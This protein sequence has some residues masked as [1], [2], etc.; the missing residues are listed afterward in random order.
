MS[1][2]R[3]ANGEGTVFQLSDG[4]WVAKIYLGQGSHGEWQV[5]QFSGKTEAIVKKKLRDYKCSTDFIERHAPVQD[6]VQAYFAIWLREYQYHKLKP[7]SFDR[8]EST[9]SNHIYPSIGNLK[10][11]KVTR[12]HIQGLI[13]KLCRKGLSYSSIKKVYV[14]LNS[15]FTHAMTADVVLKN[16]C[17]GIALPSPASGTKEVL[18]LGEEEVELLKIELARTGDAG[19][20]VHPYGQAYMLIL[21][22]G[23]RMGEALSLRWTDID[24][25]RKTI[26][27]VKNSILTKKRDE[28]GTCVGGYEVQVQKSTKTASGNRVLPM[29]QS[30]EEALRALKRGNDTE[31]VIVNRRHKPILPSNFERTFRAILKNAGISGN[32]GIHAL[33]HTFASMLFAKGVDVKI[34]SKLLGH[35]TVKI[36]YDIY[37]H[38]LEGA[39]QSVTDVLD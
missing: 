30:A 39:L 11:D 16:P 27:V 9:V 20:L 33:R 35:S 32:Y 29:N 23:M 19:E 10:M 26:S 38:L 25:R 2:E 12:D 17:V 34:V 3:R 8:L 4:K 13:N 5:K 6:T 15:C 14:A 36:T 24:F 21:H 28:E 1:S 22:T 31:Y 7:S 37:V 18:P